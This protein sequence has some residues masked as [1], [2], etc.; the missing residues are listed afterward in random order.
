M[1]AHCAD[2]LL[3]EKAVIFAGRGSEAKSAHT[4]FL[5]MAPFYEPLS[6]KNRRQQSSKER[7]H[8]ASAC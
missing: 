6:E 4:F 8:R 7:I 1:A 5:S 3:L 2:K